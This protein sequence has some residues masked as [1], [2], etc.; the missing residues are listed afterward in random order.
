[1][2][3]L[4]LPLGRST[5]V[6]LGLSWLHYGLDTAFTDYVDLAFH[7][8]KVIAAIAA[9]NLQ[10]FFLLKLNYPYVVDDF[11]QSF[12]AQIIEWEIQV[13]EFKE[14]FIQFSANH[15]LTTAYWV[16]F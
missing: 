8:V 6:R 7:Q 14:N 15:Q 10:N 3:Q 13:T 5:G 2:L 16:N 1:M 11:L 9:F 12:W 4:F